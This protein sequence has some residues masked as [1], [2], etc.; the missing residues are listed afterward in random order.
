M[1]LA[2]LHG[3]RSSGGGVGEQDGAGAEPQ[4]G[5]VGADLDE[6]VPLDAVGAADPA[7]DELHGALLSASYYG[8][9]AA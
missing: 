9:E 4:L 5:F 3:Q 1:H 8:Y 6:D 2:G 7:D